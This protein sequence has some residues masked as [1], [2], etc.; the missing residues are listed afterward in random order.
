MTEPAWINADSS[1]KDMPMPVF[2]VLTDAQVASVIAQSGGVTPIPPNPI[3]PDPVPPDP[4]PPSGGS[5]VFPWGQAIS[6]KS[7]DNGGFFCT[8][9][10]IFAMQVPAGAPTSTTMGRLAVS[11]FGGQPYT[12]Q[13][14]LA[15]APGVWTGAGVISQSQGTS[16]TISFGVG[17]NMTP[18]ATY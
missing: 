7:A 3:P 8:Q 14:V 9:T 17:W 13:L 5:V 6:W 10:L 12:R 2:I 4:N 18:G 16:V 11:E 1:P 15:N